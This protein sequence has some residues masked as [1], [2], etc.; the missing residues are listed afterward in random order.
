MRQVP[1]SPR[2]P[3]L[4]SAVLL[5]AVGCGHP[6]VNT[7]TGGSGTNGSG[8]STS[9]SGGGTGSGGSTTGSGGNSSGS[10]GNASGGSGSGGSG[11]G[12]GGSTGS[13]GSATGS[14][15]AGSGSGGGSGKMSC[16]D[17]TLP[18]DP[19]MPDEPSLQQATELPVVDGLCRLVPEREPR[20][21]ACHLQEAQIHRVLAELHDRA[22][23]A[24]GTQ[25]PC[26]LALE[27]TCFAGI[28]TIDESVTEE[29]AEGA[30]LLR[31]RWFEDV[32]PGYADRFR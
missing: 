32:P 8:G 11:S 28:E 5:V 2:G 12:S 15:G 30:L 18:A 22:Q 24:S 25:Q 10:G 17:S 29:V 14:G 19:T 21:I 4:A 16:G 1:S 13:G 3:R 23:D 6:A 20:R 27:P 9:G 26:R 7:G 31:R